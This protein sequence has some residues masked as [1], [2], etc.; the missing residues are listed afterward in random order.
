MCLRCNDHES[1]CVSSVAFVISHEDMSIC[2]C[3][4]PFVVKLL[5]IFAAARHLIVN[6]IEPVRLLRTHS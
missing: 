4:S 5:D 2:S 3:R 6:W 1:H